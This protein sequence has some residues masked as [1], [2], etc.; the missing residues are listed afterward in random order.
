MVV[1]R[2]WPPAIGRGA[3]SGS[4]L[5][6]LSSSLTASLMVVGLVHSKAFIPLSSLHATV[7]RIGPISR[8][9]PIAN[10]SLT[11]RPDILQ[12]HQNLVW[13]YWKFA[14]AHSSGIENGIHHRGRCGNDRGFSNANHCLALVIVVNDRDKFWHF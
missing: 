9:G 5:A 4:R 11:N 10:H 3:S 8:I 6:G 7:V 13:R 1:S 14:H 2:S 12:A